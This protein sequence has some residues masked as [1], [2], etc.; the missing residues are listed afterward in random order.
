MVINPPPDLFVKAVWLLSTIL[1]FLIIYY[2]INIGN[3][4]IPERKRIRINLRKVLPVLFGILFIYIFYVI[5]K[6][7]PIL[8]D[9]FFTI[10]FS[11]I[12]AYIFDPLVKFLEK[13]G[14]KR[15]YAVIIIYFIIIG[16]ILILAF[17]VV[18]KSTREIKRLMVHLPS[19]IENFTNYVDDLYIKYV[20]TL[21]GL[22]PFLQGVED[23]IGG[24][25][26]KIQDVFE[27]GLTSFLSG[28]IST[29]S[30]I[31]SIVLTPIL[32]FYFLIDKEEFGERV[33]SLIPEKYKKD[34]LSIAK[35]VNISLGQ[36][37]RGR[38]I[39]ALYVGVATTILLFIL[40][41]DFAIVIGFI[42]F[43]A[44]IIPYVG[45]FL[46]FIPA[47]ILGFMSSPI[48][49]LWLTV[50]FILIQWAE[51]NILAPKILGETTGMHPLT[52]LISIIAGGAI[53]GVLGMV[54]SVPLVALIKILFIF[55]REKFQDRKITRL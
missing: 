6:R 7:Y 24:N 52:I 41:I 11:L 12:L 45:P 43:I 48:K 38:L 17:L 13:K 53:F 47:F 35:N 16:M 4:Y 1:L 27:M 14:I 29:F 31:I 46:G 55:S 28:V 15:I 20:T 50:F 32:T 39:M 3:N 26:K 51:N 5:L 10:I 19:Y 2:L 42:T 22:P 40:G 33:K 21:G 25:L 30:K 23:I 49:A 54:M 18:P 9:T 44:D 34:I 36:F 8:S 37:V